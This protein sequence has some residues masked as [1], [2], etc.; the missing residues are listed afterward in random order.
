MG[1]LKG[2]SASFPFMALAFSSRICIN[3]SFPWRVTEEK[4]II[5]AFS[6]KVPFRNSS[7]SLLT[8]ESHSSS[9]RSIFVKTTTPS[10]IPNNSQIAR[11]S[12]VW[13]IIPSSAA[14]TKIT[15]SIPEAPAT[16]FLIKRSWPGTSTMLA[17]I[18]EGSRSLAKP[19]SMVIPLSFS[20]FKRSVSI[21]VKALTRAVFPWSIWPA[22]PMTILFSKAGILGKIGEIPYL[23]N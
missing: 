23:I 11:C 18:P 8:R 12:F 17:R 3:S 22:V 4:G 10:L 2:R 7:T 15:K 16:I 19:I 14:M 21:P 13:G 1:S 5:G 9:T 6:R 20:S